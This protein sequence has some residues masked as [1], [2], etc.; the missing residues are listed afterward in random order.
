MVGTLCALLV[1]LTACSDLAQR[2]AARKE[3]AERHIDFN[4]ETF[5][6]YV[7]KRDVDTAKLFLDA[8][9]DPNARGGEADQ[10]PL[11]YAAGRGDLEMTRVLLEV[12]ADPD[13]E[14][15]D[16]PLVTSA[17]EGHEDIVRFLL[18]KGA[19]VNGREL[20]F[21]TTALYAASEKGRTG[22]VRILLENGADVN[23]EE[24]YGATPL[25]AAA[26]GGHTEIV[27]TDVNA[28]DGGKWG[29]GPTA[30]GYASSRGYTEIARMLL[31]KKPD[32]LPDFLEEHYEYALIG[33]AMRGHLEI[34]RLFFIHVPELEPDMANDVLATATNAGQR[35]VVALALEHGADGKGRDSYGYSGFMKV[36]LAGYSEFLPVLLERGVNTNSETIDGQ[37]ALH[38][39]AWNGDI[40][41]VKY[42]I[43]YG[44]DVNAEDTVGISPLARAKF[45][46]HVEVI[47]LL[48]ATG[49]E[50]GDDLTME[51]ITLKLIS[52]VERVNFRQFYANWD[53]DNE[54]DGAEVSVGLWIGSGNMDFEGIELPVLVE[55]Y[56]IFR[57]RLI[58][59]KTHV[60]KDPRKRI[61]IPFEDIGPLLPKEKKKA[62]R[63][64]LSGFGAIDVSVTLPD[65]RKFEEQ[66]GE[67]VAENGFIYPPI[68][69]PHPETIENTF[70]LFRVD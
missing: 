31:E 35:E 13:F 23:L 33:A 62:E 26:S 37:T 3:L 22:I 69:N 63:E 27:R 29:Y 9:I 65:G 8:G 48:K 55:I 50:A 16:K 5:V 60:M 67:I 52:R 38:F 59:Q 42:L 45:K 12:G 64:R 1:T 57:D 28:I 51:D 4:T 11:V 15:W 44:A 40:E 47:E 61:R 46:G 2:R 17:R 14:T 32:P 20:G 39:A 30:I 56:S 10:T 21:G 7:I 18:E 6:A 41:S 53:D 36:V 70:P 24:E 58:Y 25:T 68:N 43:L 19:D 34:V 66:R 49:A 54:Y